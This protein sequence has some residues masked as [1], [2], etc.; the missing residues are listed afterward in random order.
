MHLKKRT[1]QTRFEK[2]VEISETSSKKGDTEV[3]N[4]R[5]INEER[6]YDIQN[7]ERH[8]TQT[9]FRESGYSSWI[10]D[11]AS[12]V[13]YQDKKQPFY[14]SLKDGNEDPPMEVIEIVQIS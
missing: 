13:W 10:P 1:D 3:E 14:D 8:K 6:S 5:N 11:P 12:L 9:T 4:L 2:S 7:V